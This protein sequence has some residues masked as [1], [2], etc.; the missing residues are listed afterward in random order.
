MFP[1]KDDIPTR[2]FPVLTVAIIVPACSSTSCSSTAAGRSG[3]AGERAR[4]RVRRDPLRADPSRRCG[5][6]RRAGRMPGRGGVTGTPDQAPWR[7]RSSPPCSCTAACCTWRATCCSCGSSATTSRTRWAGRGSSPSTCSGGWR[8]SARRCWS[9]PRRPC[10]PWGRAARSPAVLGG[11]AL[12]YPR[13]R[14]MTIIFII[15]FFTIVRLPALLVLGLWILI[16]IAFGAG[17]PVA[18]AGERGRRGGLLRAHR[19]LRFRP[20]W[21]SSCSPTT[22]TRTTTPSGAYPCTDGS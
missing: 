17:G 7:D 18:A 16:Q 8:R 14:V 22:F 9:T 5:T 11:Y 21:R 3:R 20:G 12:L 19:R 6:T 13:A 15:F 10:R 2:R 4:A 1:L